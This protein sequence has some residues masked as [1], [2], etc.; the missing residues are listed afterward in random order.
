MADTRHRWSRRVH[1]GLVCGFLVVIAG[2][3]PIMADVA[4]AETTSTGSLYLEGLH[5]TVAIGTSMPFTASLSN[6]GPDAVD[7]I[8]MV[9]RVSA[10]GV[11]PQT[12]RVERRELGGGWS[13]VSNWTGSRGDVK[14]VDDSYRDRSMGV[15]G[16]VTG[17]YRLTFLSGA[18][19]GP[20][21]VAAAANYRQENVWHA[22]AYSPQYL[23]RVIAAGGGGGGGV[24]TASGVPDPS[25]R[26]AGSSALTL[27]APT[28]G[29]EVNSGSSAGKGAAGAGNGSPGM[30]APGDQLSESVPIASR[31]STLAGMGI[32]LILLICAIGWLRYHIDDGG[33]RVSV[34]SGH[35]AGGH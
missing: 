27:P 4:S 5:A 7:C 14:F 3:V 29:G 2:S 33:M 22:L 18:P 8:Q 19:P 10:T 24:P 1:R 9:L 15:G 26:S 25:H 30:A 16:A 32:V 12:L 34:A 20:A 35:G 23:T 13:T 11:D 28:I 17:R 31:R 21:V 6:E